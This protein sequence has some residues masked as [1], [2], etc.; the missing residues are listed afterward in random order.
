V[1]SEDLAEVTRAKVFFGHQSVGV[2]ILDGVRDVYAA[3]GTAPPAIEQG[4]LV[5]GSGG[6]FIDHA[7]IG[8]NTKPL[9][10]IQDFDATLRN[11]VG[12]SVDVALMKF[13]YVDITGTTNVDELFA[14][15]RAALANLQRDFPN[16]T[17]VHATVPLTTE[18]GI[19]SRVKGWL[20][21]NTSYKA[22]NVAR[23]RFN[24]LIRHEYAGSHLL[25]LAAI[26]STTPD[27]ARSGGTYEGQ[28]YYSLYD[29]YASDPGHLNP[30]GAQV[31][32]SAWLKTVA[33][34]FEE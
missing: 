8:E 31:V 20:T 27:G 6:G 34:A 12:K 29:G 23:E 32:A 11:G 9:L 17:F 33:R 10:K 3:H 1:S 16:V 28:Q 22:D 19:L 21:G 4:A 5:P 13:C 14:A 26:E 30:E 24:Q 2:N 25:D 7:F 15:Y 18:Q